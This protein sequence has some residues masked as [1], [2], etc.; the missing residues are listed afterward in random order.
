MIHEVCARPRGACITIY[1]TYYYTVYNT[2]HILLY[3]I[4]EVCSHSRS[5]YIITVYT[6]LYMLYADVY[7]RCAGEMIHEVRAP[8]DRVPASSCL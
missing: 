3:T 5:A 1:N 7:M 4:H 8:A 6:L 2:V